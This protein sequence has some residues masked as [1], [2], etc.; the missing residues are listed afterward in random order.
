MGRA[1]GQAGGW[2]SRIRFAAQ[3]ELAVIGVAE[4]IDVEFG[5]NAAQREEIQ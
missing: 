5:E 2:G 3:I 1:R 4:E